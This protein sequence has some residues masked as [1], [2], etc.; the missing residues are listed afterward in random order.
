MED[1]N[2]IY[3]YTDGSYSSS[4]EQMGIGIIIVNANTDEIIREFSHGYKGGT[5]NKAE[6]AAVIIGLRLITKPC[7]SITIK[8]DSM[9]VIG[10]LS[11]N[12]KRNKNTSLLKEADKQL[13]RVKELC[14][15]IIFEHVKG[16]NGEKYNERCDKLATKAS[17]ELI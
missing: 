9:L 1:L 14:P 11:K 15:N 7:N 2:N 5:N 16:H 13:K 8:T 3:I 10:W 6:I 4:R 12:W 17:Q